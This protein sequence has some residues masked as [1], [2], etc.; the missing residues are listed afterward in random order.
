MYLFIKNWNLC[1]LTVANAV[2]KRVPVIGGLMRVTDIH[3][4]LRSP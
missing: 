2:S 3:V 4:I 1:Y